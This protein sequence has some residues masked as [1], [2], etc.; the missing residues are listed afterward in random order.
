MP[1]KFRR[2]LSFPRPL[3]DSVRFLLE[4]LQEEDRWLQGYSIQDVALVHRVVPQQQNPDLKFPVEV[5]FRDFLLQLHRQSN[6]LDDAV[7]CI[8][9]KYFLPLSKHQSK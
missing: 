6:W 5:K 8:T 2:I 9:S 3:D 4:H 7:C 1:K